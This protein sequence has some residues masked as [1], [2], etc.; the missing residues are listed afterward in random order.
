MISASNKTQHK[1]CMKQKHVIQTAVDAR[2]TCNTRHACIIHFT[3]FKHV[4]RGPISRQA[5]IMHFT[6]YGHVSEAL[7]STITIT[8]IVHQSLLLLLLYLLHL[9]LLH[10]AL[11]AGFSPSLHLRRVRRN[12]PGIAVQWASQCFCSNS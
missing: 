8:P 6:V 4:F 9:H 2:Y 12:T 10:L 7:I 11:H 1:L 3:V 5:C